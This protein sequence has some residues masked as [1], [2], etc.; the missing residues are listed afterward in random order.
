[1]NYQKIYKLLRKSNENY[2]PGTVLKFILHDGFGIIANNGCSC[3][4]MIKKMDKLGPDWCES[5]NGIKEIL[6]VMKLE[7]DKRKEDGSLRLPWIETCAK[8]LIKLSC[9]ASKN[10]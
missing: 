6:R 3:N 2:G 9:Y 5:E 4:A 7:Y 1:M 8:Q 10:R